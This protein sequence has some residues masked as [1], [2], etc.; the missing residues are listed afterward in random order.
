MDQYEIDI[1]QET[2]ENL[3]I[4]KN[5]YNSI[6]ENVSGCFQKYLKTLLAEKIKEDLSIYLYSH[7]KLQSEQNPTKTVRNFTDF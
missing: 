2:F 6:Y 7:I 4:C 1:K 3:G 5:C